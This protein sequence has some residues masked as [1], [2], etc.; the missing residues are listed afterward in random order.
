[1]ATK[2]TDIL[3]EIADAVREMAGIRDDL[4]FDDMITLVGAIDQEKSAMLKTW[5]GTATAA[6]VPSGVQFLHKRAF[7]NS[8]MLEVVWLPGSLRKIDAFAFLNCRSL[9]RVVMPEGIETVGAYVAARNHPRMSCEEDGRYYW[10]PDHWTREDDDMIIPYDG[11]APFYG[12][13]QDCKSLT[14]IEFPSSVKHIGQFCL[15]GCT[16]L[17]EIKL[18]PVLGPTI[19]APVNGYPIKAYPSGD[20][21]V[22]ND[23]FAHKPKLRKI[24]IPAAAEGSR[25][26]TDLILINNTALRTIVSNNDLRLYPKYAKAK[27]L[28]YIGVD[29]E[30]TVWEGDGV[31]GRSF[32]DSFPSLKD[33]YSTQSYMKVYSTSKYMDFTVSAP[34]DV[35]GWNEVTDSTESTVNT[36]PTES[37]IYDT[38]GSPERIT[39]DGTY[40]IGGL[41]VQVH[42]NC[43][44]PDDI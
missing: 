10:Q 4:T 40:T 2:A 6:V 14:S 41:T 30:L 36:Y 13:F 7:R 3:K 39:E 33:I 16:A 1:M 21:R 26:P 44:L 12:S 43:E 25:Y 8:Q 18:P 15:A 23:M 9:R 24:V 42:L 37:E 27:N 22:C 17:E 28:K 11:G 35:I 32:A 29:G 38:V 31:S 19:Y 5:E 20:I 34:Q